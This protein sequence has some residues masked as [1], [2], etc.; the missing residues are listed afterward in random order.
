MIQKK[1]RESNLLI[2]QKKG[3]PN[4]LQQDLVV[5][6]EDIELAKLCIIY[7]K[8]QIKELCKCGNNAVWIPHGANLHDIAINVPE[9]CNNI[10]QNWLGLAFSALGSRRIQSD[11]IGILSQNGSKLSVEEFMCQYEKNDN[12]IRY[13]SK[14]DSCNSD[15]KIDEKVNDSSDSDTKDAQSSSKRGKFDEKVEIFLA[16]FKELELLSPTQIVNGEQ[17]RDRLVSSGKF[18][19]SDAVIFLN[20]MLKVERIVETQFA[21]TYRFPVTENDNK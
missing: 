10:L 13:F 8:N 4:I 7:I 14:P 6:N 19:T 15:N 16:R 3:L 18:T 1:Y 5:S 20:D 17:F 9:N 11:Q 2:A 21:D 12:L